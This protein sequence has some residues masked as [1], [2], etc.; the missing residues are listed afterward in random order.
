MR[1]SV[2]PPRGADCRLV[3]CPT[4]VRP[5]FLA[6]PLD[7]YSARRRPI[8][9]ALY[10]L[11]FC[12]NLRSLHNAWRQTMKWRSGKA[13]R[14]PVFALA[15]SHA[16]PDNARMSEALANGRKLA[17][18][19]LSREQCSRWPSCR[20]HSRIDPC[21]RQPQPNFEC[22]GVQTSHLAGAHVA[23]ARHCTILCACARAHARPPPTAQDAKPDAAPLSTGGNEALARSFCAVV[24]PP[25]EYLAMPD[26]VTAFVHTQGVFEESGQLSYGRKT[27]DTSDA[28][29]PI[30][31]LCP[32]SRSPCL[33]YWTGDHALPRAHLDQ[34]HQSTRATVPLFARLVYSSSALA[35]TGTGV[36]HLALPASSPSEVRASHR[37]YREE[38]QHCQANLQQGRHSSC[39]A[40]EHQTSPLYL[41]K[42]ERN[43]SNLR[44]GCPRTKLDTA[45]CAVEPRTEWSS[46]PQPASLSLQRQNCVSAPGFVS[47]GA[48]RCSWHGSPCV[49]P[50][51]QTEELN[52]LASKFVGFRVRKHRRETR[53]TWI[54]ASA[55]TFPVSLHISRSAFPPGLRL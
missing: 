20:K 46:T 29:T 45:H 41:P 15:R 35:A 4:D 37:T 38:R 7:L 31:V 5:I 21:R 14:S 42:L 52:A 32:R 11:T 1:V 48:I 25:A 54:G 24:A 34:V 49:H 55:W 36:R 12:G 50:S 3:R 17:F 33:A 19:A 16:P 23:T 40:W 28:V 39:R 44:L 6:G 53:W 13:I 18:P 8:H 10:P 47:A 27:S 9:D 26:T 2:T 51:G 22:R 43:R 30:T